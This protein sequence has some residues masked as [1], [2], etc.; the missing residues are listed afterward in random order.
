MGLSASKLIPDLH[1][2][3]AAVLLCDQVFPF[4]RGLVRIAVLQLLGSDKGD[5]LRKVL[6]GLWV[7]IPDLMLHVLDDLKNIADGFL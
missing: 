2:K 5:V 1:K 3:D 4:L 6:Y 7:F